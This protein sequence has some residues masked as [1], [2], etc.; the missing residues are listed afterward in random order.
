MKRV[1]SVMVISVV[2]GAVA[3]GASL[4][5]ASR[6]SQDREVKAVGHCS[7][8]STYHQAMERDIGVEMEVGVESGV[9]DQPWRVL[10]FYNGTRVFTGVEVTEDDGG[11]EIKQQPRNLPGSDLF[12]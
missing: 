3:A 11:F 8:G 6:P 2:A 1:L 10:M 9:P 12:T 4:A 5:I 7:A